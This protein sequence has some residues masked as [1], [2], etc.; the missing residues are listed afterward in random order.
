MIP[1]GMAFMVD[2]L[3]TLLMCHGQ[4]INMS[5][6]LGEFSRIKLIQIIKGNY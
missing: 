4:A 5:I 1:T 3:I 2:V 6:V